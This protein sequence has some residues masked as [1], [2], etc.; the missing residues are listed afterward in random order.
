MK[1][2]NLKY[3]AFGLDI[4]DSS[5]KIA[6][7]EKKHGSFYLSS[8]GKTDLKPGVVEAGVIK[9]EKLLSEA[10]K[11]T[12]DNVKGKKIKSKYAVMSL[13]E[14]G[15]FMQ[16]IQMPKM[17]REELKTAII[18]EAENYIPL[19]ID[20]VCLDF[21]AITPIKNNLDHM[22][23]LVVATPKQTVVSYVSCIKSAGLIPLSAEVESQS[24]IRALIKNETDENPL[25]VIDIGKN[26]IDLIIFS[27]QAIRFTYSIQISQN[28]LTSALADNLNVSAAEA[29]KVKTKYGLDDF[30]DKASL[31][32]KK[33]FQ[34]MSPIL[35]EFV[36]EIKKN[37]N[38]Y[39]EHA[40]HEH[41]PASGK[42]KKI[43]LCGGG[44]NLK[45]LPEFLAKKTGVFTE[46]GDPCLNLNLRKNK[47]QKIDV[48]PFTTA[49]GLALGAVNIEEVNND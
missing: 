31:G 21:Q 16:V 24:I 13:P 22:D 17:K 12:Y 7:L 45:K 40:T 30:D 20:Q 32:A 4:N 15:S 1:F 3:D 29:E 44:A 48:L 47:S 46:I 26:N 11:R 19:P 35:D 43:I 33:I 41:L 28:Q 8:F 39:Q 2:L 5:V 9:N 25:V 49:I 23:V 38:F 18:F 6:K 14:E 36:A 34:I 42:I 10:I 27:G 37:V